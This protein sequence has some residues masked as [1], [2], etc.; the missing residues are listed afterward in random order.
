MVLNVD[1]PAAYALKVMHLVTWN[2]LITLGALLAFALI[3]F[4]IIPLHHR[5]DLPNSGFKMPFYP[6]LPILAELFQLVLYLDTSRC[7]QMVGS[8]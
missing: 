8:I 6:D 3:S 2:K 5:R 1:D 4:G 7:H